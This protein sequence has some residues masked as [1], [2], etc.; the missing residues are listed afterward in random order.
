MGR[1]PYHT[2]HLLLCGM[3]YRGALLASCIGTAAA[4][5]AAGSAELPETY[6]EDVAYY[7]ETGEIYETPND[8]SGLPALLPDGASGFPALPSFAES[9]ETSAPSSDLPKCM[10]VHGEIALPRLPLATPW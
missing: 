3:I 4:F 5:P 9:L 2:L 1:L 10:F 8:A 6:Y 7:E